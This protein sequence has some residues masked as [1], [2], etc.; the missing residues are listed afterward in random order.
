MIDE[1]QNGV[2]ASSGE[3][4]AIFNKLKPICVGL[5][6]IT[7]R[8]E[9]SSILND[10]Q[11]KEHLEELV[12]QLDSFG[13]QNS[14]SAKL[15]DYVFV[16]ISSMLKTCNSLPDP[17]S[18]LVFNVLARVIRMCWSAPGAID[19]STFN[20]LLSVSTF[21][22]SPDLENKKLS[23]KSDEFKMAAIQ[24]LYDLF[25]TS[26]FRKWDNGTLPTIAH[27]NTILLKLLEQGN[28]NIQLESSRCLQVLFHNINDGEMLSNVVP[29]NVST[30]S[31]VILKPGLTTHSQVVCEILRT[32]TVLLVLVYNDSA[33]GV[34]VEE[35]KDGQNLQ[36]KV[37]KPG[38]H[39][40]TKWLTAT[41]L[42]LKR[43]F[44][45]VLEK[46]V[47]RD[48]STI[49]EQLFNSCVTLVNECHN[50][51][52]S[53]KDILLKTILSIPNR[54]LTT[55]DAHK[56]DIAR[57]MRDNNV[58]INTELQMSSQFNIVNNA[59]Q[60]LDGDQIYD[61]QISRII[62]NS[63]NES[64]KSHTK[65]LDKSKPTDLI[66]IN[67]VGVNSL[68]STKSSFGYHGGSN[69]RND[70]Y[71][72]PDV[73]YQTYQQ[74]CDILLKLGSKMNARQLEEQITDL[75]SEESDVLTH[76]NHS[77]WIA[78]NLLM[79]YQSSDLSA[80]LEIESELTSCQFDVL[81]LANERIT[82]LS[83]R[84]E[85]TPLQRNNICMNLYA[86][87][88]MIILM[89]PDF[90]HEMLD[91]I[92]NIIECFANENE[93]VSTLSNEILMHIADQFY[94]GS[95]VEL[96]SDNID[97][98][99]DGISVRLDNCLFQRAYMVL[100]VL[101]KLSGYDLVERLNDI[102]EKL[103]W[104][105]GYYHGY[106]DLCVALLNLF[107]EISFKV[108][109]TFLKSNDSTKQIEI[110]TWNHDSF[111]PWGMSN[112]EQVFDVLDKEKS[113]PNVESEL[114]PPEQ[115]AE[116]FFKERL[117]A[118]S[119]D[120][121]DEEDYENEISQEE[122]GAKSDEMKWESPIPKK[123]Y[124]LLLRFWSYSDRL[125][126]HSSRRVRHKALDLLIILCPLL[127][128]QQA[129]FLPNVS[130]VWAV[131]VQLSITEDLAQ[132]A[133]TYQ[134]LASLVEYTD[135]F[136][137]KKVLDM[138]KLFLQ[139][140]TLVS[141]ILDNYKRR[142]GASASA[143]ASAAQEQSRSVILNNVPSSN[144]LL[145]QAH[146]KC[147]VLLVNCMNQFGLQFP[148]H[149]AVQMCMC[150]LPPMS[151]N[152]APPESKHVTNIRLMLAHKR[153]HHH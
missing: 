48:N 122:Q 75:L 12:K 53:L 6:Q 130:K 49:N 151:V 118:D 94:H 109:D 87:K 32:L 19:K 73:S 113:N 90:K 13:N 136:L 42:Q 141:R 114:E 135:A 34:T 103:F 102:L 44:E 40:T 68:I 95:M 121:V 33:L 92:Y 119:D 139:R 115:T 117:E 10:P 143:S 20:Q 28:M 66:K 137:M 149:T 57:F 38:K 88:K 138:W 7:F 50:A 69:I 26:A 21:L 78:S 65:K 70:K 35:T 15:G 99:V 47:K 112:I 43:A 22:I 128:T 104:M 18:V 74:V 24:L 55:L 72:L 108:Q 83:N 86:L 39:R 1:P 29:G 59:L 67:N 111:K 145:T 123:A 56:D 54:D 98:I 84:S 62:L 89:G 25:S 23:E 14:L 3:K 46:L 127:S 85:W 64:L 82:T 146:Q 5:S 140:D 30:F 17:I 93:N 124:M 61:L 100:H 52:F 110:K 101:I 80:C 16:P 148:D 96:I 36:V 45:P 2:S 8:K 60:I 126:T 144:T 106:D 116:E 152:G 81:E 77:I 41:S 147:H 107:A 142:T 91:Y 97:Y 79:G 58:T 51:F 133:R 11:L 131:V 150:L 105:L 37:T 129:V 9:E 4:A 76:S 132:V 120:E 63:I 31:K 71:V 27:S 125:L 153:H 134:L